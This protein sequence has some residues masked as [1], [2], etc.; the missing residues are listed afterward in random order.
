VCSVLC[1]CGVC[2]VSTLEKTREHIV[3]DLQLYMLCML[4]R[5]SP[6]KT[7]FGLLCMLC[8]L[9]PIYIYIYVCVYIYIY[10]ALHAGTFKLSFTG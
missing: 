6:M 7:T 2:D 10:I 9:V 1:V 4:V 8:M 3:S 5:I